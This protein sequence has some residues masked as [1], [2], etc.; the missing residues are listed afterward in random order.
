M[1]WASRARQT[2]AIRTCIPRDIL[3]DRSTAKGKAQR[4]GNVYKGRVKLLL[5][6]VQSILREQEKARQWLLSGSANRKTTSAQAPTF[7]TL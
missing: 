3:S 1:K 7:P 6:Q 4:N 5:Q 2:E